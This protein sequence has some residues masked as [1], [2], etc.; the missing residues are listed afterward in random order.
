MPGKLLDLQA[1]RE[2]SPATAVH[3]VLPVAN[4]LEHGLAVV[5]SAHPGAVSFVAHELELWLMPSQAKALAEDLLR[6]AA[7]ADRLGD[8]DT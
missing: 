4:Q 2:R 8:P 1:Y 7:E 3:Y 6:L 5:M